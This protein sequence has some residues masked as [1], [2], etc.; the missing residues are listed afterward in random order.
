MVAVR[1]RRALTTTAPAALEEAFAGSEAHV[2]VLAF[3]SADCVQCHRLQ[4]PSLQRVL[5]ARAG[6]VAVL[7]V[8]A[9]TSPGLTGRYG[10]LTVPSTVVLDRAGC[11]RAVNFG[12]ASA[13]QLL[14]QV[15]AVL[16]TAP[17]SVEAC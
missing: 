8:D 15:D 7:D 16:G 17:A 13:E 6:R 4:T 3:S 10:I 5:A 12:F 14:A 11:T 2:R 9:P 1:K